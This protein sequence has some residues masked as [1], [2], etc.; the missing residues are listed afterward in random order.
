MAMTE[1]CA[2]LRNYFVK[3]KVI[4]G[5]TIE[6]GSL[7]VSLF[8]ILDGQYFRIVG[9]TLNDGVYKYPETH[10]KDEVFDG[11]IWLLAI[12]PAVVDLSQEIDDWA[13]KYGETVSSP[14][15]NESFGGYSYSKPGLGSG[16][17]AISWQQV[18][19]D[20]LKLWR[21]L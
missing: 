21:K 7:D 16:S 6:N 4:G 20:K 17:G 2:Y 10:L 13:N 12:P 3:D 14:F 18:F 5:F 1:L 19:F 8:S 9:S 15:T 11:E